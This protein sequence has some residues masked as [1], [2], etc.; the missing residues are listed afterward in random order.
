MKKENKSWNLPTQ[1]LNNE[2]I[3]NVYES[4]KEELSQLHKVTKCPDTF[5]YDLIGRIQHE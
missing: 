4:I 1:I 2:I 3:L 5:I